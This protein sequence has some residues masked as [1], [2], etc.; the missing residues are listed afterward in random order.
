MSRRVWMGAP[1]WSGASQDGEAC[2]QGMAFEIA[3][4]SPVLGP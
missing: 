2:M 1:A 3:G 4:G